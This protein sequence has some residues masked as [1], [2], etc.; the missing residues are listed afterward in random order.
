MKKTNQR[1]KALRTGLALWVLFVSILLWFLPFF[2]AAQEKG[3]TII[4]E[5]FSVKAPPPPELKQVL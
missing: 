3:K 2:S 4:D 1:F 5:W